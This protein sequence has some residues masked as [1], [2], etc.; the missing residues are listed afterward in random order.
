MQF[1]F[2][3]IQNAAALA[4]FAAQH[5]AGTVD[6][7]QAR[8]QRLYALTEEQRT[9]VNNAFTAGN[10]TGLNGG[11]GMDINIFEQ[12]SSRAYDVLLPELLWS[13]TIPTASIDTSVNVGAKLASYRV[14]DRRGKGAFRAA[15]G[16]DIPQVGVTMNK[17]TVAMESG[18]VSAT[19]DRDD[20][21]AV[22]FG[23]EGMNLITE[24]GEVMREAAERHIER[25]FFYGYS[26]LGFAG[27][28][29]Y[30]L[31][32]VTTAGAKV[33]GGTT[34]ANATPDEMIK[35]VQDA[36]AQMVTN[37]KGLWVPD[38]VELPIAQYLRLTARINGTGGNGVNESIISYLSKNN[39]ATQL[40]GRPL[41]FRMLR[42]L[43]GAGIGGT[44][45]M[46]VSNNDPRNHWMPMSEAFNMLPPQDRQFATDL[47]A[48]YKFGSYH[49]PYP[50][51]S[52]YVDG[53]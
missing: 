36:I 7:L 29:D 14:K 46:A 1:Q 23:Y 19:V 48:S 24:L 53:I 38:R 20:L 9:R 32:P 2:S 44:N 52:L 16:K 41:E 22:A 8:M 28:L 42:Y 45:R 31:V 49:K 51:S 26:A 4:M 35:D 47:F 50:L 33:G 10:P 13:K 17:V 34:W 40:S 27:Y 6:E 11:M 39:A 43:E 18:A 25:T 5:G 21:L 3:R 30:A 12:V 37:S 15:V